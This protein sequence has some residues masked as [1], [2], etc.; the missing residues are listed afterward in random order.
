M[1]ASLS[2]PF[3]KLNTLAQIDTKEKVLRDTGQ[4]D[5]LAELQAELQRFHVISELH[6]LDVT[7][8]EPG[9]STSPSMLET[10]QRLVFRGR[11]VSLVQTKKI[12]LCGLRWF[13]LNVSKRC[14]MS[15]SQTC[16]LWRRF[17]KKIN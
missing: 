14:Q 12:A 9:T 5:S 13:K 2:N 3:A 11:Y 15:N 17:T 10:A 6:K 4:W 8:A 16:G 7:A 1:A